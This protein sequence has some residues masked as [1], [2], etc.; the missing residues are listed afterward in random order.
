MST[1][2]PAM[3]LKTIKAYLLD[4]GY[5]LTVPTIGRTLQRSVITYKRIKKRA[6][7]R[8]A[9]ARTD[10]IVKMAEYSSEQLVFLDESAKDER[11]C[12]RSY[13]WALRGRDAVV[14]APF[15]RG[16]RSVRHT[17]LPQPL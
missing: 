8:S 3:C 16:T 10:F 11:T 12:T 6:M 14:D 15:R 1:N 17:S 7:E 9:I 13:E 5:Q 4:N 2:N